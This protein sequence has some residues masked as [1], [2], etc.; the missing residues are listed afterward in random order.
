[1]WVL[2]ALLSL[3]LAHMRSI[4]SAVALEDRL[5]WFSPQHFG[6]LGSSGSALHVASWKSGE[7]IISRSMSVTEG[8]W[9][10]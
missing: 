1:M 8:R 3:V 4:P 6:L 9:F 2:P 10:Y 7:T 5:V